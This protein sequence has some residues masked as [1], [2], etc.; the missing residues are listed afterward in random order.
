MKNFP[1]QLSEYLKKITQKFVDLLKVISD[2]ISEFFKG[3]Q[4]V[5]EAKSAEEIQ[6]VEGVKSVEE[7]QPVREVKSVEEIKSDEEREN[8]SQ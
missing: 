3:D 7:T 1:Q 8:K 6:P 5:E 2:K 4:S